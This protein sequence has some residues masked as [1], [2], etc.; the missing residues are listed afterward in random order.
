MK[1]DFM[2]LDKVKALVAVLVI[3]IILYVGV[4]WFNGPSEK[5]TGSK[6][7]KYSKKSKTSGKKD[8]DDDDD[9]DDDIQEDADNLYDSVHDSMVEGIQL[10][11]FEELAGNLADATTFIELKKLYQDSKDNDKDPN[12]YITPEMYAKILAN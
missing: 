4:S 5:A 11:D 8:D 9:I 2:K 1:F 6:K 7:N 10:E 3:L 12:E